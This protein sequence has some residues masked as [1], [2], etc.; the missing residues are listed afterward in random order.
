VDADPEPIRMEN[1]P[2]MFTFRDPGGNRL[3]VVQRD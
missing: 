1:V 2:P 3:R